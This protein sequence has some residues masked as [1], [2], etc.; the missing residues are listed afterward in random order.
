MKEPR[1]AMWRKAVV[2]R[3]QVVDGVRITYSGQ[4]IKPFDWTLHF[5]ELRK[6]QYTQH[7][8]R[9]RRAFGQL[10]KVRQTRGSIL[11]DGFSQEKGHSPLRTAAVLSPQG[12]DLVGHL[13]TVTI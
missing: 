12:L 6:Q 2:A 7:D 10:S 8:A 5:F 4:R 1:S 11:R 9:A 13:G 3:S